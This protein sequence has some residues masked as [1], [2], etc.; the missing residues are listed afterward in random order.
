MSRTI[1]SLH[2]DDESDWRRLWGDY[3]AFYESEVTD[4]VYARTFQRL[5]DTDRKSQNALI[6]LDDDEPVGLVHYIYHPHNWRLEDVCYLQDLY[7]DSSVRGQGF[8]RDLINAVYEAADENDTPVVYWLT[9]SFNDDARALYDKI[10]N[11]TP[12]IKYQR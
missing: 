2:S 12:F 4:E 10:A 8:G 3:L 9:Q 6:A 7:V 1:R 5:L 11:E